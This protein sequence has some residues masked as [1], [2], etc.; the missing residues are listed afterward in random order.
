[1]AIY[2]NLSLTFTKY[3]CFERENNENLKFEARLEISQHMAFYLRS[4]LKAFTRKMASQ[5]N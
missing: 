3:T 2:G 4:V 5:I 1:M